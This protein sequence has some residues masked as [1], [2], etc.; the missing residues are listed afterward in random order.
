VSGIAALPLYP[1]ER[2]AA[3]EPAA[4][5]DLMLADEDRVPRA[6]IDACARRGDEMAA[7]LQDLAERPW[8]EP[9]THGAWWLRLHAVMILGLIPS[10][11]AGLL[12]ARFM[13]R[14]SEAEDVELQ[15]WL[16]G[17]WPAL[18]ANKPSTVLPA[19][20]DLCGDRTLHWDVRTDAMDAVVASAKRRG[21]ETLDEAL[22][23]LARFAGDEEEEWDLRLWCGDTLLDFPRPQYRA[24]LEDLAARQ[25]GFGMDFSGEDVEEA[26]AVLQDAPDW[27]EHEDPWA[28]YHPEAIAARQEDWAREDAEENADETDDVDDLDDDLLFDEPALPYIRPAPKVGRNDPCP[29]GSGKKYKKCCLLKEGEAG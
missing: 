3:L 12:L 26:Y 11:Q 8:A 5:I 9:E 1:E 28:F 20:R 18:F 10:E 23:W 19:L 4:L 29:C 15:D 13:R 6:V 14:M 17:H 16:G 7:A 22:A 25:R 21:S 27:R 2:L 24:L